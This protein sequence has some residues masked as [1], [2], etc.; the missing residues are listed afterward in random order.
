MNEKDIRICFF[1]CGFA[2]AFFL[3]IPDVFLGKSLHLII[4]IMLFAGITALVIS[5]IT[6]LEIQ[7]LNNNGGKDGHN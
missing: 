4:P 7:N 6:A 3:A 1:A 5:I 2:W